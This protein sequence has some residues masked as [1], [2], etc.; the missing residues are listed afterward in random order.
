[1]LC[2]VHC[3]WLTVNS[4]EQWEGTMS[5]FQ[6]FVKRGFDIAAAILG[7]MLLSPLLFL[8]SVAIKLDSRGPV[9]LTQTRYSLK[10]R[11]IE[12]FGFRSTKSDQGD[13]TSNRSTIGA[14]CV[15]RIGQVLRH[16][17]IDKIP[18][19]INVL[20]G[21]ISIVGTCLY[22]ASPPEALRAENSLVLHGCE[23]KPGM[24]G[25]AQVSSQGE[26]KSRTKALLYQI[27]SDRYYTEN[28]S[29]SFDLK[30]ILRVFLSMKT[31]D[32]NE[33]A[34]ENCLENAR[35]L[36]PSASDKFIEDREFRT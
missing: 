18:E 36:R 20:R 15:T 34:D 2:G 16:T 23:A 26:K 11:T 12:L 19:L 9:L 17:E 5:T 4:D 31:Y 29:F 8:V 1:M 22:T 24:I 3:R 10:G 25:W 30:I 33:V 28:R 21:E 14:P 7:L 27:E 32:M 6:E 35:Y 13:G